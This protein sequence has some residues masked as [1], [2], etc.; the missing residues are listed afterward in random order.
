MSVWFLVKIA[1][2]CEN[3]PIST[4]DRC[5]L[6]AAAL[7]LAI[8]VCAALPDDS[9]SEAQ[10]SRGVVS[11]WVKNAH[12]SKVYPTLDVTDRASLVT[13]EAEM[14][15]HKYVFVFG[16]IGSGAGRGS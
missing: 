7:C 10:P 9:V 5:M 14:E 1:V 2:L 6:P 12:S 13:V 15:A 16:D 4:R 3:V 11:G 8:A